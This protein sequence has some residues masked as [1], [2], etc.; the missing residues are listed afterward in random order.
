MTE[1]RKADPAARRQA[2]VL[3]VF[4]A[5]VGAVLILAFE[6]SRT[7]LREWLLSEP[8]DLGRRVRLALLLAAALLAAPL[9]AFAVYFWSL[10]TSVVQAKEFP[11]PGYRV[12]RDTRVVAGPAAVLRGRGLKALALGLVATSALLWLLLWRLAEALPSR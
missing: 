10:G 7:P 9:A 3:V 8:G 6:R 2:L 5:A 4:G 1:V 11:P 12:V